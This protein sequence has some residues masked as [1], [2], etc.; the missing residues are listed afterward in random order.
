MQGTANKIENEIKRRRRGKIYFADDFTS[1]GTSGAIKKALLRFERSGMLIRLA[2]G[3]YLYPSIDK[4]L[5]LGVLYPSVEDVA[6]EIARRDKARIVPTGLYA[7]NVLGLSTQVPAN[8]VYLTDGAPRKIKIYSQ[9]L[10]FKHV[11]PKK[12]AYKSKIFMLIVSALTEIGEQGITDSDITIVKK[13]LLHETKENIQEDLK[14]AP[15]W[16]RNIIQNGK[17]I[18]K[19]WET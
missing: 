2:H 12:L 1:F 16:I 9:S 17:M 11:V 19:R 7:L 3:I 8:I 5:G 13:A 10:I 6:K 18:T 14:L 4:R 15:I